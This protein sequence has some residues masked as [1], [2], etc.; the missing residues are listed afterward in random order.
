M[1]WKSF[2]IR[3]ILW[4]IF[5][6]VVPIIAIAHKYDFVKS[7]NTKYTGWAIIA[8]VIAFISVMVSLR[9]VLKLLKRSMAK[10]VISGVMLVIIPLCF[11]FVLTDL[12]ANNIENI[13]YILVVSIVSEFV[14][15][16][17]NPFP[18]MLWEKNI[19]DIKEALK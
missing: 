17:I 18:K 6:A 13:K 11:L 3:L 8:G 16:P 10:Q 4:L 15:I 7:G 5:S 19:R 14:A 2:T 1:N 12:I 9:Y